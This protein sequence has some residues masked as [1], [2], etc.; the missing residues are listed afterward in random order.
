MG[1]G[2][3]YGMVGAILRRPSDGKYLILRRSEDKDFAGGSWECVTGRVD[4]GEGFSEAVRRE[5]FEELEINVQIDFI[6]GT[7]HFYRGVEKPENEII[8]V[9]YCCTVLEPEAM[10]LSWEH[11]DF[12]LVTVKEAS[13]LLPEGY[14]LLDVIQRAE[15]IRTLSPGGLLAFYD[16]KGYE[17]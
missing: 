7:A 14:W 2:R 17:L 1:I 15:A 13:E 8:G 4:Q 9:Q 12:R 10:Q 6:V 3:F 11:A 5:V 16:E